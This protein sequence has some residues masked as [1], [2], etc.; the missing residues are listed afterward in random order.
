MMGSWCQ[1][2]NYLKRHAE[3]QQQ[4]VRRQQGAR[5]QQ[6]PGPL[7]VLPYHAAIDAKLRPSNLQVSADASVPMHSSLCRCLVTA[8]ADQA[9]CSEMKQLSP[10]SYGQLVASKLAAHC[11]LSLTGCW[12]V[13]F[14]CAEAVLTSVCRHSWPPRAVLQWLLSARTVHPGASTQPPVAMLFCL[15][16]LE[17]PPNTCGE[18]A[19]DAWQLQ[20]SL[21]HMYSAQAFRA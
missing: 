2:E 9:G 19:G 18:L 13:C 17:T 21:T 16:C 7:T 3:A 15:I 12:L 14:V 4:G 1:V 11:P 5:Q 10:S 20:C 6:S 8:R